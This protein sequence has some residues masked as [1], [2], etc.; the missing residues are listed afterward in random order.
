MEKGRATIKDVARI[1]GVSTATVS[2]V[3]NQTRYVSEAVQERVMAAMRE[4]NY[5]SNY[6][7]KALRS[8]KSHTI[9]VVIP[10]ISNPFYSNIVHHMERK[11]HD[12]GYMMILCDSRESVKQEEEMIQRLCGFQVDGIV[13]TPISPQVDYA[14]WAKRLGRPMVFMDRYPNSEQYSGVFCTVRKV[15]CQ[16]VEQMI[17]SGH[18]CIALINRDTIGLY[19]IVR[20]RE[21]GYRD[22]LM[23][24]G[25]T[26][27]PRYIF[28]IPAT[29]ERGYV[30]MA[31][32]LRELPEVNG[33]FCANRHISLGALQC[34]IDS[35]RRIPV[36]MSIAGFATYNWYNVTTPRLSSVLEPLKEM[37]EAVGQLML[38]VLEDPDR[39]P[40]RIVLEAQLVGNASIGRARQGK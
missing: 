19:S 20:E 24:H 10:D 40:R 12:A 17:L 33:V 26:P 31:D 5:T 29:S 37:G 23:K 9:G 25:I 14:Q 13:L 34:L 27:D 21:E 11:L 6:I 28:E 30:Q 7:A 35:G 4:T 38:E 22:A 15:I 1:A 16:A 3:M 36:D 8:S 32:I 39:E 2:H 18:D